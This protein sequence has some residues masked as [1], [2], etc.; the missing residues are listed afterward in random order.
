MLF[1]SGTPKELIV[2]QINTLN[3]PLIPFTKDN[4]YFGRPHLESDGSSTVPC[5][6]ML[7]SEYTG[8]SSV[9]YKR[10]NLTTAY[11]ER[12]V[13]KAIVSATIHKMLPAIVRELGLSL[14]PEDVVD[15]SVTIMNPGEEVNIVIKTSPKSLAYSGSFII[16]YL[17]IRQP[18]VQVVLSKQ[19]EEL[20]HIP[21]PADEKRSLTMAMY[22]IDFSPYSKDLAAWF[23]TFRNIDLAKQAAA[24]NGFPNWPTPEVDSVSD[25][26]TKSEPKANQLFDRVIIQKDVEIDGFAGDAYFHYNLV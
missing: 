22:G 6:G 2:E 11:D 5:V 8:Y 26:S 20:K 7:D 21:T 12:P 23:G 25:V 18:L 4:L 1:F 14:T 3:N 15:G 24:E 13:L 10:I 16:R 9:R 19:I 17:R